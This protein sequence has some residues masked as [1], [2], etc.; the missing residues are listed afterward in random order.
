MSSN[1]R[2]RRVV[3]RQQIAEYYRQAG[4][5]ILSALRERPLHVK[6]FPHGPRADYFF[7]CHHHDLPEIARNA[8]NDVSGDMIFCPDQAAL[9][10]LIE[11]G[12][13]S[14]LMEPSCRLQRETP[15]WICWQMVGTRRTPFRMVRE[16]A[17]K[18]VQTLQQEYGE[19]VLVKTSDFYGLDV[20]MK[21]T[22]GRTFFEIRGLADAVAES[23]G[24]REPMLSPQEILSQEQGDGRVF[25]Y[26]D[27]NRLKRGILPPYTVSMPEYG[28]ISTPVTLGE[29]S[30]GFIPENFNLFTLASRLEK[31]GDLWKNLFQ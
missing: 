9:D 19:P 28:L 27:T 14:M 17:L 7:H 25:V 31:H 5:L 1:V 20:I 30:S 6:R 12:C 18:F 16:M 2:M 10:A 13:Y 26:T 3:T 4:P 15:D 21:N 22:D 24:I 29:L 8:I 11:A 23:T